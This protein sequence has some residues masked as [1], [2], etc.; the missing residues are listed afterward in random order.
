MYRFLITYENMNNG[1]D[2]NV[3]I[4]IDLTPFSGCGYKDAWEMAAGQAAKMLPG[5]NYVLLK[6]EFISA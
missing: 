2:A 4:D 5:D 3:T 6:I 1:D